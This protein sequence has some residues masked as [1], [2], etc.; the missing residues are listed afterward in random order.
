MGE[1][2]TLMQEHVVR[3][4]ELQISQKDYS[5]CGEKSLHTNSEDENRDGSETATSW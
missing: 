1:K 2:K 5:E 3:L 4:K